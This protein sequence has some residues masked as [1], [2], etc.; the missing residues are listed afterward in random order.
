[1]PYIDTETMPITFEE[2]NVQEVFGNVLINNGWRMAKSFYKAAVD[3]RAYLPTGLA[4]KVYYAIAKHTIFQNAEGKLLGMATIGT[5]TL[6]RKHIG[7]TPY[8]RID[9]DITETD[10]NYGMS[11]TWKEWVMEQFNNSVSKTNLY[12]YMLEKIPNDN[13]VKNDDLVSIITMPGMSGT[14]FDIDRDMDRANWWSYWYGYTYARGYVNDVS[15]PSPDDAEYDGKILQPSPF[16]VI[17]SALDA[18]VWKTEWDAV[19]K[20]VMVI[21][22]DPRVLQSPIVKVTLR[23]EF[24][25][26]IDNPVFHTNWWTDSEI[27]VKGH[28]DSNSILLSMRA[29]NAPVWD[30]NLVPEVPFYFG[31]IR[32]LDGDKDEGYALFSGTIPP[33]MSKNSINKST[34]LTHRITKTSTTLRVKDVSVLPSAPC[35]LSLGGSEI[36]KVISK[37]TTDNTLEVE[38]GQEGTVPNARNS[39]TL[40]TRVSNNYFNINNASVVALFDFDDRDA[41]IGE[42]ILPLLKTYPFYPSNG[43]DSVMVSRSRYGARYQKHYLSWNVPSNGL[44]PTRMNEQGRKYRRAY[45]PHENTTDYKYQFNTSR[46]SNKVHSSRIFVVHPEEGVRGYLD[47]SL[48]FDSQS[49]RSTTLKLRKMD[50]PKIEHELYITSEIGAVSPLT[51]VPAT[52]FRPA[53]LGIYKG[54]TDHLMNEG[55]ITPPKEVINISAESKITKTIYV[56]FTLPEDTDFSHAVIYV[57]GEVHATGISR[58]DGYLIT[59]LNEGFSP[60]IRITTVDL[61]GNESAGVTLDPVEVV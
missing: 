26:F 29:D 8:R 39:G 30:R 4:D 13:M 49:V 61:S 34:V 46:Y 1:M 20:E 44:P 55:D 24:L 58:V 5:V 52:V 28:I 51:K 2:D 48:A 27:K 43:V 25:E 53:G 54:D 59:G 45:E 23:A 56:K 60:Q 31:K 41:E 33:A 21:D 16:H 50:C 6:K 38:R 10:S 57:D 11:P 36:V 7:N 9:D 12:F 35:F 40:V 14:A 17:R 22:A 3:V 37:D 42:T 15:D 47:K 19:E 32:S 18:E